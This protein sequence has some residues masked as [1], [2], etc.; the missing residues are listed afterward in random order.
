M[1]EQSLRFI[2]AKNQR[3]ESH[4]QVSKMMCYPQ[5]LG[6]IGTRYTSLVLLYNS[7][8]TKN[9]KSAETRFT[10]FSL[11]LKEIVRV[12]YFLN[13]VAQKC[14]GQHFTSFL[15]VVCASQYNHV[16]QW[17]LRKVEDTV[18]GRCLWPCS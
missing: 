14:S 2:M 7:L 3:R 13:F 9:K 8:S 1:S 5:E 10:I 15:M 16:N 17:L 6:L 12:K 11:I 18:G 4:N